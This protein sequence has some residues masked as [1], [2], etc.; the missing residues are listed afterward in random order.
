MYPVVGPALRSLNCLRGMLN[1]VATNVPA[2][3]WQLSQYSSLH[4]DL[5][6]QNWVE[7]GVENDVDGH[8]V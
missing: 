8:I 1:H 6:T 4:R 7:P 2:D 3:L 5:N